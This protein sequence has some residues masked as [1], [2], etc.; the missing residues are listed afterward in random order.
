MGPVLSTAGREFEM[1]DADFNRIRRLLK[2]R[3]GIDVGAGKRQLVYGRLTRRLRAL[4]LRTFND[5][6]ALVEDANADEA[7]SFLNSLTTNVTELFREEHHFELLRERLVPEVTALGTR[8]LR[9]WSAGCS[10]GDEPYSIALTLASLPELSTWDL[11]I[12]ATDID[13]EVLAQGREGVYQMDRI[14]KLKP[15]MRALFSRGVGSKTGLARAGDRL[16][17]MITFKQLNLLQDWPM[18]GPFDV[19]F[20]RNVIIYFDAPT[21][22][23]LV[24]RFSSLL[25]PGGYLLLGHSESPAAASAPLLESSGRTAFVRKASR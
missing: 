20:C 5:Y 9:I 11:K 19:I 2:D 14:A 17:E 3:S 23:Q 13:S 21:K 4:N 10:V 7:R 18:S 24:R 1:T 15:N 25:R 16:R 6:L 22:E 8:R 12:L